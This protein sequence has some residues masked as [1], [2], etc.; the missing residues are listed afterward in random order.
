[1][2]KAIFLDKDGTLLIDV[3]YNVDPDRMVLYPDTGPALNAMQSAGYRLVVISNQ[4]GV[5]RGFF[6][7]TALVA[8]WDRLKQ[9][10]APFDANVDGFYHCPHEPSGTVTE[11]AI[12]CDCR[13]PQPGLLQRAA[14]ELNL[15]LTA[16]W[17]IGDILNDV[18]AGNRAGCRTILVDR[19]N[20]TEWLDGA[21]RTP[22]AHV[23]DLI[24]AWKTI[25]QCDSG[26]TAGEFC[27]PAPTISAMC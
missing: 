16:S 15:D 10:L 6:A 9:L 27:A 11:Y 20:E 19:G 3:P 22:T 5:A 17:M 24:E 23:N 13:K 1:M 7:E 4:S 12:A 2:D 18:E 14:R 21:F 26:Q 25:N 8:V